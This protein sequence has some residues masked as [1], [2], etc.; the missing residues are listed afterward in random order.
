[1][2]KLKNRKP[3]VFLDRDGTLIK[4]VGYLAEPSEIRLYR[5]VAQALRKLRAAGYLLFV[6][7]NQSGVARGYFPESSVKKVHR[8]LQTRLKAQ[9]ARI[10][11]F[12]YCPHYPGAPLKAYAKSCSCR[13]PNP[14]MVR[15][16]SR[17][18][19][20]D[21][22]KSYM[23]GDKLDDLGL[24]ARAGLAGA[25]LVRTGNGRRSEREM[26]KL[27]GKSPVVQ[28]VP[29]AVAAILSKKASAK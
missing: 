14:G 20:V 21:L 2:A 8:S 15:Q 22:K 29:Q 28:G 7:T 19:A 23:V 27:K 17:S 3:A 4:D 18:F 5:G 24:A 6:V 13:K 11:G 25:Y 1:M 9:G 16:A 26:R 10:D 12:Y